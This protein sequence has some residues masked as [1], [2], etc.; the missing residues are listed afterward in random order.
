[1]IF[2]KELVDTWV[3]H[4]HD[5]T[6][7]GKTAMVQLLGQ[8]YYVLKLTLICI[9]ISQRCQ[10]YAIT[11]ASTGLWPTPGIQHTGLLP[12]TDLQIDFTEVK[13]RQIYKYLLVLVCTSSGWPE[14]YSP[15]L[16]RPLKYVWC[17]WEKL[18][19]MGCSWPLAMIMD[20]CLQQK[21]PEISQ[22]AKDKMESPQC[23]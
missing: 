15:T 7:G 11:K 17:Y 10:I 18:L 12:F 21:W 5:I 19:D 4:H 9:T 3:K 20:H 22:G 13:P 1:M 8:Y 2:P 23:L 14:Y 16:K 6:H